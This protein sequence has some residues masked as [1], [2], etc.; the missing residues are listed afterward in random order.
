MGKNEWR[1]E[2]EW[3]LARTRYTD[4]YLHS[5]GHAG[6]DLG[7]GS[8]STEPPGRESQDPFV[9]DPDDPVPT[10]G[11]NHSIC[12]PDAFHVIQPDRSISGSAKPAGCADLYDGL[13]GE[14]L[15]LTGPVVLTFLRLPTRRTPTGPRN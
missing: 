9:Y 7:D 15:E 6:T 10:I 11:G 8:L 14:D 12:W 3:P 2:R 4:Y 1:H 13:P 5:S